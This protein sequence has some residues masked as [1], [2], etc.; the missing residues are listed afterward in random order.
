MSEKESSCLTHAAVH[1]LESIRVPLII[2]SDDSLYCGKI[3]L[4]Q[5]WE[6]KQKGDQ[7][8]DVCLDRAYVLLDSV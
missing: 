2:H 6:E 3:T 4:T 5:H 7:T 8:S 1:G